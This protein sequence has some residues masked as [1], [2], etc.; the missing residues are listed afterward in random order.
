MKKLFSVLIIIAFATVSG[1]NPDLAD[2]DTGEKEKPQE[3]T[4]SLDVMVSGS[5]VSVRSAAAPAEMTVN[6]YDLFVFKAVSNGYVLEYTERGIAPTKSDPVAG[7]DATLIDTRQVSLPTAGGKTI[8]LVANATDNNVTYPSEMSVGSLMLADF[9]STVSFSV[10][11]NPATP[12]VMTNSTV[13]ANADRAVAKLTLSRQVTKFS[14]E[15]ET[16]VTATSV[17]VNNVPGSCYPLLNDFSKKAPSMI[18]YSQ[19]V[20]GQTVYALWAPGNDGENDYRAELKVSGQAGGSGY[21]ETFTCPGPNYADYDYRLILSYEGGAVVGVWKPDFAGESFDISGDKLKNNTLTF[22]FN[23]DT[24]FGYSVGWTTDMSGTPAITGTLPAWLSVTLDAPNKRIRV[25]AMTD[26]MTDA[27]RP[28]S[29]TVTLGS[30][31]HTIDVVQQAFPGTV[32]FAGYEWL[33][34]NLGATAASAESNIYNSDTWGYYYQWGRCVPFPNSG[35][36]ETSDTKLT[37]IDGAASTTFIYGTSGWCE[38]AI[39]QF[40]LWTDLTAD[41]CPAGYHTPTYPE[42]QVFL[43]YTN[44]A[45]RGN[46]ATVAASDNETEFANVSGKVPGWTDSY[47]CQY[48]TTGVTAS[49]EGGS[50]MLKFYGTDKAMLIRAM[51]M[52]NGATGNIYLKVERV[53]APAITAATDLG[54]VDDA[55]A[56]L[57]KAQALFGAATQ[58]ETIVFPGAGGRANNSATAALTDQ[59]KAVK[60][61]AGSAWSA[62]QGSTISVDP[63]ATNDRIYSMAGS[64]TFGY[65]VRCMKNY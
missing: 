2:V 38:T 3:A 39:S 9:N 25:R 1:C 34:R 56:R 64:A 54:S 30:V 62:T 21:T 24:W 36:V 18:D 60:L 16:G 49:K 8:V 15:C 4:M 14:I 13:V 22:P 6:E 57:A 11:K 55:S 23:R 43:P 27:E 12:F 50:Y 37:A 5:Y 26:N 29:F 10:T 51:R 65:P 59:G 35:D 33:D 53:V 7:S 44:A 63:V 17:Q 20:A 46:F 52:V 48:V 28:A 41:P 58:I 32:S 42:V 45:G 19:A 31:S 40:S 61:W 47:T